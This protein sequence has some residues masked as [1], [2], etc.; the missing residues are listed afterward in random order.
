TPTLEGACLS[1]AATLPP[2]KH[3]LRVEAR[4]TSGT[5]LE[6]LWLP[7][8]VEAEPFDWRRA[9]LYMIMVDRFRDSDGRADPTPDVPT[10]S[11]FQGGDLGGVVA[12]LEDGWF[13]QLGVDALWL[14][15]VLDNAS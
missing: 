11:N 4:D 2:G 10:L 15:P 8:W 5:P 7:L 6:P 13:S 1:L 3:S 12:A 9:L 14:T